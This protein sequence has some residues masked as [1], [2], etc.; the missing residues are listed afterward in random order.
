MPPPPGG[1]AAGSPQQSANCQLP[2]VLCTFVFGPCRHPVDR[3]GRDLGRRRVAEAQTARHGR[4]ASRREGDAIRGGGRLSVNQR[5]VLEAVFGPCRHQPPVDRGRG[6]G[7][8]RRHIR[9]WPRPGPLAT[10]E[11]PSA[12][13]SPQ[14]P[15][16]WK[17]GRVLAGAAAGV[18]SCAARQRVRPS[19]R[20]RTD[21][22][23]GGPALRCWCTT[24]GP[25][26]I[27]APQAREREAGRRRR[28]EQGPREGEGGLLAAPRMLP[29]AAKT[30]PP[31]RGSR[32]DERR[33]D[34]SLCSF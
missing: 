29:R 28:G 10:A 31:C 26:A 5:S 7:P 27:C 8:G 15:S 17:G 6:R 12:G 22:N 14:L 32:E 23:P 20:G 11:R 30:E 19:E 1:G 33:L 4:A 16:Y 25:P 18:V 21:A 9:A 34:N 3:G 24:T 13:G 2:F